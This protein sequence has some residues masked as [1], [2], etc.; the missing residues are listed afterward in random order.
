MT[1]MRTFIVSTAVVALALAPAA[2]AQGPPSDPGKPDNKGT[3]NA[4]EHQAN[5]PGPNASLPAKAK[6]YG[7]YCQGESKKHV[8]GQ[9]GTPFSQCVTAMA[10]L[11]SGSAN[12]PKAACAALS[13]K[14]VAGQRGTP[15]SLCVAGAAKL[16]NDAEQD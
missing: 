7:V 5:Q 9:T 15:Y 16:L 6:A 8:A 11:A 1:L 13:K 12:S 2:F 3:Q 4:A 14:H 10:K